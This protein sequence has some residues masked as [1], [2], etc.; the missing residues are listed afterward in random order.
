MFALWVVED[1][2]FF[3]STQDNDGVEITEEELSMLLEGQSAGGQLVPDEAGRPVLAER[4]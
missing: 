2:R 3:F 4:P 1:G